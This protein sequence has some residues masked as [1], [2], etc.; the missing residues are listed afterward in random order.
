MRSGNWKFLMQFNGSQPQLYDLKADQSEKE[1]I[2]AQHPEL[3]K[4]FRQ[5][6]LD[7]DAEV[8]PK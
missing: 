6:L 5:Q 1:N 3:V 8:S 2:A 4:T 7:W